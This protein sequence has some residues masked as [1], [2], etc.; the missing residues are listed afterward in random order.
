MVVDKPDLVVVVDT[1]PEVA[2]ERMGKRGDEDIFDK[3]ETMK[4]CQEGYYWYAKNSGDEC[5]F[6]D[7]LG[8]KE[9]VFN[10]ILNELKKRRII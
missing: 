2:L 6:V 1:P 4:K 8:T 7:G 5:V 9:E 10:R 3:L